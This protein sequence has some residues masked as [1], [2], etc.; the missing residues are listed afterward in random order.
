MSGLRLMPLFCSGLVLQR[1]REYE[2]WGKSELPVTVELDGARVSGEATDGKFRVKLPAHAAGVGFTMTVSAGSERLTVEDICF[3]DVFLFSG[4]SNFETPCRRVL[5]VSEAEIAASDFPFIREYKINAQYCFDG[6]AEEVAQGYWKK[7]QGADLQEMSAAAFFFAK[8]LYLA[9][10]TPVG[11]VLNAIGGSG[12]S[13]WMPYSALDE[14]AKGFLDAFVRGD[15]KSPPPEEAIKAAEKW[16]KETNRGEPTSR[17]GEFTVP[18]MTMGTPLDGMCGSV[19]FYKDVYLERK[20]EGEGM[21][22][23][24]ELID[25]DQTYINGVQVGETGYRYPP[26][27]YMLP[28]GIL[29]QGNNEIKV[30]LLINGGQGGFIPEHPYWL[31]DRKSVV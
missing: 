23:I 21:I 19:W 18:G 26:R 10:Q 28:E 22:Y 25:S 1:D 16:N 13:S 4:Q 5:D 3:G 14:S 15:F 9:R 8:E 2:V 31:R 6:P 11:I 29:K 30:R 7:A 20:P 17:D 12:I 24:G 27:K